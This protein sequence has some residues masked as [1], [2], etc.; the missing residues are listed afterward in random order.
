VSAPGRPLPESWRAAPALATAAA[1][2][3]TLTSTL[4][5]NVPGRERLLD[6]V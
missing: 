1:G 2:V 4:L 5:P 6:A 3:L